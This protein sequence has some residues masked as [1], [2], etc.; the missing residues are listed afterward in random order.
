MEVNFNQSAAAAILI[1]HSTNDNFEPVYKDTK[2]QGFLFEQFQ[3]TDLI[4]WKFIIGDLKKV[5]MHA[6]QSL[7]D[8]HIHINQSKNNQSK[9]N[10]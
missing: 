5:L 7:H 1:A 4:T 2:R 8:K 3:Q 10:W 9:N 6:H